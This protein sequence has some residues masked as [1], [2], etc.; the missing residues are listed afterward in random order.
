MKAKNLTGWIVCCLLLT[1]PF[2]VAQTTNATTQDQVD[3]GTTPDSMFYG[4]ELAWERID[5]LFTFDTAAKAKKGLSYATERLAEMD[6]MIREHK[7]GAAVKALEH[8]GDDVAVVHDAV[9]KLQ[10][11]DP[12]QE[13]KIQLETETVLDRQQKQIEDVRQQADRLLKDTTEPEQQAALHTVLDTT[14]ENAK[15]VRLEIDEHKEKARIKIKAKEGKSDEDLVAIEQRMG[16]KKDRNGDND[17]AEPKEQEQHAEQDYA[18]EGEIGQQLAVAQATLPTDATAAGTPQATQQQEEHVQE[19]GSIGQQLFRIEAKTKGDV[20][21]V[22]VG[23]G[24]V[25]KVFMVKETSRQAIVSAIA[26]KLDMDA[27]VVD[28]ELKL[29]VA[30]GNE[31][32][33]EK[34]NVLQKHTAEGDGEHPDKQKDKTYENEDSDK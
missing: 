8:Y 1:A 21:K 12:E 5:L 33:K 24:N 23:Q 29:T 16:V 19:N 20:T 15:R 14:L 13:L 18:E 2:A 26:T 30:T 27:S 22:K 25:E 3:P 32:G 28:A 31:D 10:E 9:A 34:L 4:L 6:A 17:S 11:D 7:A